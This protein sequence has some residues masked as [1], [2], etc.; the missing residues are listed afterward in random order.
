MWL[1][2]LVGERGRGKPQACT[3]HV[4]ESCCRSLTVQHQPAIHLHLKSFLLLQEG[5]GSVQ[6]ILTWGR[7]CAGRGLLAQKP[8]PL[9]YALSPPGATLYSPSAPLN[10]AP[11]SHACTPSVHGMRLCLCHGQC[12]IPDVAGRYVC[13]NGS[14]L[15][16]SCPSEYDGHAVG[17]WLLYCYNCCYYWLYCSYTVTIC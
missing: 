10:L 11:T 7:S 1:P 12:T 2:I 9:G 4:T 15:D 14:D 5:R 8:L 16:S 6:K 17:L 3:K 13:V